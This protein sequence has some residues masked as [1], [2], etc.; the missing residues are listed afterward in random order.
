MQFKEMRLKEAEKQERSR[1]QEGGFNHMK[2]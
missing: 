2:W 1:V